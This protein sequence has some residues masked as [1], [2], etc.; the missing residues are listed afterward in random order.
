MTRLYAM[1]AIEGQIVHPHIMHDAD[2]H[3]HTTP[4]MHAI[5]MYVTYITHIA[6]LSVPIEIDTHTDERRQTDESASQSSEQAIQ[7]GLACSQRV[8]SPT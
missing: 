2:T 1:P 3:S 4:P 8:E 5:G 6:I 7:K